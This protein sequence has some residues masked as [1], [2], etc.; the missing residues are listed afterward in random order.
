MYKTRN[1]MA[2]F[3]AMATI[4]G[5]SACCPYRQ[6]AVA[7][8]Q[9]HEDGTYRGAFIDGDAIQVN[10]EIVL[11]NDVVTDA[12]FRHLR[13]DDD[14]HLET[15]REPYQSVIRQYQESL[16]H[17]VGKHLDTHLTD[18]YRPEQ[19]VSTEVDGYS[20]ATIRSNKIISAIRDALNRGV[21]SY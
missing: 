8:E 9:A 2:A 6:R 5:L 20:A 18:L 16:D 1:L 12:T 10:I 3:A 7:P 21:Y 19:I 4:I 11:A 14:Y 13:R 15:D 17:L